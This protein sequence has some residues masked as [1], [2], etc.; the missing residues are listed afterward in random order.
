MP[1]VQ[2]RLIALIGVTERAIDVAK[3]HKQI[4]TKLE[5]SLESTI[6]EIILTSGGLVSASQ[7]IVEFLRPYIHMIQD[8]DLS[9]DDYFIFREEQVH[10]KYTKKKNENNR[11]Y[12][13][14]YRT[15]K[16]LSK[17][18]SQEEHDIH[19][20]SEEIKRA[21]KIAAIELNEEQNQEE[22]KSETVPEVETETN[23]DLSREEYERE[24]DA[25]LA[26][27]NSQLIGRVGRNDDGETS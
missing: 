22:P 12:A 7:K 9:M 19:D 23:A 24:R 14:R 1:I 17:S 21:I 25:R 3:A 11:V 8:R 10:F 13:E 5:Q 20:Q 15:K 2:E 6:P 4:I 26:R 16:K 27:K 18:S